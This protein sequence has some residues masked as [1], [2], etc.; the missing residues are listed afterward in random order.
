MQAVESFLNQILSRSD[1]NRLEI[2]WVVAYI[3]E[4]HPELFGKNEDIQNETTKVVSL[5]NQLPSQML[6]F[7]WW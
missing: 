3:L 4:N 5:L 2:R 1:I 6:G 7:R